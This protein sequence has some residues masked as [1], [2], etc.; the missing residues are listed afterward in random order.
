MPRPLDPHHS[1]AVD[2]HLVDLGI[3]EQR[4]ERA[5]AERALGDHVRQL[6]AH[7]LV[8]QRRLEVHQRADAVRQVGAIGSLS[9]LA[10]QP[11]TQ[12]VRQ[13]VKRPRGIALHTVPRPHGASIRPGWA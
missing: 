11:L 1:G 5:E 10:K 6:G 9:R 8:Q 4:L 3:G 13:L 2:H 12:R 7:V